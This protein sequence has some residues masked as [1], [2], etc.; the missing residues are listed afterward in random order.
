MEKITRDSA[1]RGKPIRVVLTGSEST[2]KTTLA[3]QLATHYT[4]ELAP[5]FVREFAVRKGSALDLADVDQIALGQIALAD[6]HAERAAGL[7]SNLLVQ[8]TDL[9]STVVYCN[10]YYGQCADWITKA[11]S[12]RRPDLYLLLDID[13]P[14]IPDD[15]RDRGTRREEMQQLFRTAVAASGAPYTVIRG[16]WD[17]RMRMAQRAVDALR[18]G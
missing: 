4:A 6:M 16:T 18:L 10:H 2:G 3:G 1:T 5:E 14:W 15:V 17:E 9:L 8:D 11:A 12:D 13:V 7:A